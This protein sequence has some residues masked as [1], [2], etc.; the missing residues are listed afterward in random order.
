[1]QRS[2]PGAKTRATCILAVWLVAMTCARDAPLAPKPA[3]AA[4][5]QL[6][7]L[8]TAL[9]DAQQWL[10]PSPG[11]RDIAD[12]AI[13]GRLAELST[14]LARGETDAFAPRI[15]ATRQALDVGTSGES[16]EQVI[17]LA[18]LGLV[19]DGVEAVID[20]RLQLVPFDATSPDAQQSPKKAEQ[21]PTSER[22][23][24]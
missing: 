23:L 6:T 2:S 22:S 14:S 20:G 10:L 21:R 3:D 9:T 5:E 11:E 18:A 17:Q 12:D 24:P 13:A 8:A 7:A 15:A 4:T 16:G 19:L 1:M